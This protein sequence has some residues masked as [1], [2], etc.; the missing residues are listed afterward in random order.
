MKK[1]DIIENYNIE[2]VK[3]NEFTK[4]LEL[5]RQKGGDIHR[6]SKNEATNFID[7]DLEQP[8]PIILLDG[9]VVLTGAYPN[10]VQVQDWLGIILE[11]KSSPCCGGCGG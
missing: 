10:L 6:L 1:L 5:V 3:T 9:I 2:P 4:L 7:L 11:E 8:Y